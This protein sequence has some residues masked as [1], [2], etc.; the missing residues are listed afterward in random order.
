MNGA[1]VLP[2]ECLGRAS[3]VSRSLSNVSAGFSASLLIS[4]IGSNGAG[5]G[6]SF[7][8]LAGASPPSEGRILLGGHGITGLPQ[9]HRAARLGVTTSFQATAAE[10]ARHRPGAGGVAGLLVA[11][12]PGC[13][14]WSSGPR[15]FWRASAC[16][17]ALG[18][19][20]ASGAP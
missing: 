18:A 7:D 3:G 8:L 10:R 5:K 12:P 17:T 1:A 6:T 11:P 4:I 20:P 2:T 13:A 14:P 19:P 9:Q 16:S 15:R